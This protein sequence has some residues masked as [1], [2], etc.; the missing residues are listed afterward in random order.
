MAGPT[1]TPNVGFQVPAPNQANWNVPIT[2][3]L[4]LLDQIFGGQFEIP[5]L[6]VNTLTAVNIT[7]P[8][9][10]TAI[11]TALRVETPTGSAPTTTYTLSTT[12]TVMLGI[13]IRGLFQRPGIDYTISG[14][15]VT[16]TNSTQATDNVFAVYLH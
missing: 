3:D 4:T 5:A 9:V 11:A 7:L 10:I 16:L 2:Y 13:Y 1:L 14:T 12:P 15:T 6:L 8:D